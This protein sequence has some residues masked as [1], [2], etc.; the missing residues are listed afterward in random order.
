MNKRRAALRMKS[1][2]TST[3]TPV[4]LCAYKLKDLAHMEGVHYQ[5]VLARKARGYYVRVQIKSLK[6]G[7][8]SLRYLD[9]QS[10]KLI[11][12]AL[13]A[14]LGEDPENTPPPEGENPAPSETKT[15]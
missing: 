6:T 10:S 9:A 4:V 13:D 2:K 5:T 8:S 1:S 3:G 14:I 12:A 15:F 11:L 7:K